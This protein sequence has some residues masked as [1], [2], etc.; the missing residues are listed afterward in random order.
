MQPYHVSPSPS[1]SVETIVALSKLHNTVHLS[2]ES[3]A[4]EQSPELLNC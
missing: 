1:L 4:M 2:S 3:N